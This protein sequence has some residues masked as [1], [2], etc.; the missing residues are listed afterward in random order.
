MTSRGQ[1]RKSTDPRPTRLAYTERQA[2]A[3]GASFDRYAVPC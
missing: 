1:I 2:S 3:A